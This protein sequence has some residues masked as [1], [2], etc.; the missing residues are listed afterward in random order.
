MLVA[1]PAM[2]SD[3]IGDIEYFGYQ[4]LD[5]AKVRQAVPVHPGDAY[6]DGTKEQVRQAVAVAIG[7]DPT[8]VAPVCCDEKGSRLLYIGLPGASSRSFAYNPEPKGKERLP[9]GIVELY[10]RLDHALEAAVHRGGHAAEEDDSNGYALVNDPSARALQLAVHDWAVGHERELLQVL[11][12]SSAVEQRR[13]ASDAAGY[14]RQSHGQILALV[15]AARDP[16]DEVR[17]NATRAL[18][19]LVRSNAALAAQIPAD[20]FIG[21]LN[22]ATWTDRNKAASLLMQLT[23]ARNTDLLAKLRASALDSLIE[24]AR[25]REAG[26]AYFAR[27]VLGRVAGLPEDRLQGL[28]WNGPVDAIIEAA[29]GH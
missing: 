27:M 2:A 15:R 18:G 5:L 19:V 23:A 4:G 26:H 17:N 16:D 22:S 8:D 3:H 1:T 20:T 9:A 11:E 25:W 21:M 7:K 14:L 10:T 12:D 13:V 24:M 29:G 28:A 6:S